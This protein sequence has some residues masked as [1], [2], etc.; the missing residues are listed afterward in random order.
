MTIRCNNRLKSVPFNRHRYH[1]YHHRHR[2]RDHRHY[3]PYDPTTPTS[4]KTSLRNRLHI[5]SD[6]F[7]ILLSRPVT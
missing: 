5:P 4:M 2:Q 1:Q 3:G 7:A 6:H